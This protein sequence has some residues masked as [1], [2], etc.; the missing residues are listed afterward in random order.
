MRIL[1]KPR[2]LASL[3]FVVLLLSF[4]WCILDN[5]FQSTTNIHAGNSGPVSAA[6]VLEGFLWLV[7]HGIHGAAV[8]ALPALLIQRT[9]PQYLITPK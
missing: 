7:G 5:V 2:L 8:F 4:L 9:T 1:Y 3:L 6:L